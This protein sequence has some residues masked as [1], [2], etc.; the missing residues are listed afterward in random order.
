MCWF[1]TRAKTTAGRLAAANIGVRGENWSGRE[2]SNLRPPH[3]Q[4][5]KLA[6]F[7]L[8]LVAENPV[9]TLDFCPDRSNIYLALVVH[10]F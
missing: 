4:L 7:G 5:E 6:L 8:N 1:C 9:E 3:P 2:D 10:L